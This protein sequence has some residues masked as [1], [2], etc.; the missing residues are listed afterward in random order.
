MSLALFEPFRDDFFSDAM[1]ALSSASAKALSGEQA[2]YTRGIL[3]DIKE[4]TFLRGFLFDGLSCA[5]CH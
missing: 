1:R 5:M 2:N 4:V 3:V